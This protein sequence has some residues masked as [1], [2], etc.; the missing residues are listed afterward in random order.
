MSVRGWL[1][2]F[3]AVAAVG[4]ACVTYGVAIERTAF[5]VRGANVPVLPEGSRPI[6]VLHLSDAHLLP[7]QGRKRD[8]LRGLAGLEPDL[9]VSTGDSISSPDAIE[10]LIESL[11]RLRDVPGVFVFG[12]N[13]FHQ[14]TFK[15]PVRYLFGHSGGAA[16]ADPPPMPT[17]ELRESLEGLGWVY[18]EER[19][20]ELEIAGQRLRFRGTGDAHHERDDYSA[21]AGPASADAVEIGVTH[22]PYL[23]LLDAMTADGVEMIFAGHTHGGQ[24]CIP[25]RGALVTNCDLPRE[26][27]SGL[28]T[29]DA[30][31]NESYVNVSAGIGMSPFAPYRFACPPEVSLLT[32]VPRT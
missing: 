2:A 26:H 1:R 21:V 16:K 32:L 29:Y 8:F 6:R 28:F 9:V 23:R 13:D 15:L 12:S 5:R 11:G 30:G 31:G 27:A 25:G 3:G 14:P 18:L 20:A 19:T 10:P 17:G 4:A 24:V 7:R 22:A